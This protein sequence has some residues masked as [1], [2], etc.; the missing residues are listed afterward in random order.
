MT[1]RVYLAGGMKSGWQDKV[2]EA[3]RYKDVIFY[4]PRSHGFTTEIEYTSWDLSHAADADIVFA[5]LEIDNPSGFGLMLEL[6]YCTN[7]LHH[8]IFV[9]DPNESRTHQCGMARTVASESYIGFDKGIAA[10][11]RQLIKR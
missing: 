5:Y 4:D 7:A 6:G 1:H 8:N 9:E 3:C 11:L 2:I 10:L